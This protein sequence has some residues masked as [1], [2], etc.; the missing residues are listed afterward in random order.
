MLQQLVPMLTALMRVREYGTY[1]SHTDTVCPPKVMG[2]V[3]HSAQQSAFNWTKL[4]FFSKTK[5]KNK[6]LILKANN[7]QTSNIKDTKQTVQLEMSPN[8]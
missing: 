8:T 7:N 6:N 1:G 5:E 4:Y 3:C 2:G